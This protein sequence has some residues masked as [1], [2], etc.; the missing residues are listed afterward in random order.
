MFSFFIKPISGSPAREAAQKRT[1]SRVFGCGCRC[2]WQ[3]ATAVKRA[4]GTKLNNTKNGAVSKRD[5][6]CPAWQKSPYR[7]FFASASPPSILLETKCYYLKSLEI[8][9]FS[10]GGLLYSRRALP[11]RAPLRL[12]C[13][14]LLCG[15]STV[16]TGAVSKR[17]SPCRISDIFTVSRSQRS[18]PAAPAASRTACRETG[19]KAGLRPWRE[20]ARTPAPRPAPRQTGSAPG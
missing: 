14:T 10:D 2:R 15:F 3:P 9:A 12:Y 7:D 18:S 6:P 20:S 5:S 8:Q 1:L 16:S 13:R 17:D 11:P 19:A 4:R